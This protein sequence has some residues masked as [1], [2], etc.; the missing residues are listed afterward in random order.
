[1]LFITFSVAPEVKSIND[2]ISQ[3]A[4]SCSKLAI[5]TLEQGVT[6]VQS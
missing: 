6:Y 5:E 2:N 1:M 3:P 4:I